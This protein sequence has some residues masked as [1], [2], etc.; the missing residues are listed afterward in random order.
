VEVLVFLVLF[1]LSL[2]CCVRVFFNHLVLVRSCVAFFIKRDESLFRRTLAT[3]Q[4][5]IG[6]IHSIFSLY[7]RVVGSGSFLVRYF[8][9]P[10][11]KKYDIYIISNWEKGPTRLL[12]L[13]IGMAK[14]PLTWSRIQSLG[15]RFWIF[16]WFIASRTCQL[17]TLISLPL[18]SGYLDISCHALN[19]ACRMLQP[20][21]F[22]KLSFSKGVCHRLKF[23]SVV[24]LSLLGQ[25]GKFRLCSP[26][27]RK[28]GKS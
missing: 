22:L 12:N 9:L 25:V 10:L 6:L 19:I 26:L 2:I 3:D 4:M 5:P 1:C 14:W 23:L 20:S 11:R 18:P 24:V 17:K 21:I 16:E 28:S 7:L 15:G 27:L 8:R 13:D